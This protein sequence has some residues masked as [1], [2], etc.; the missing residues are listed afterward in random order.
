M[1]TTSPKCT[2]RREGLLRESCRL[3]E[4]EILIGLYLCITC[5]QT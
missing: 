4:V 1:Q 5:L 3:T 2:E